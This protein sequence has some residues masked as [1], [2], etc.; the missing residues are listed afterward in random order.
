ML[1]KFKEENP[2]FKGKFRFQ[3]NP[4]LWEDLQLDEEVELI[5]TNCC[6]VFDKLV[7]IL[8]TDNPKY[9]HIF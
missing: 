2:N 3:V 5:T 6:Y 8:S 9:P 4:Y 7:N 1:P